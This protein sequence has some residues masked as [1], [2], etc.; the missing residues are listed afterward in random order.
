M[1]VNGSMVEMDDGCWLAVE[2]LEVGARVRTYPC[3]TVARIART[4]R[5]RMSKLRNAEMSEHWP[6]EVFP[7]VSEGPPAD[8][9]GIIWRNVIP[10]IV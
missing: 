4:G 6:Y 8:A 2:S 7:D 9:G 3:G 1:I 5:R 10:G